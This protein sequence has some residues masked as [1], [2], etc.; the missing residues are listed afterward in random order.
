VSES[1]SDKLSR[2][3]ALKAIAAL[4]AITAVS[5]AARDASA[6]AK[7]SK[8]AVKYQDQPKNGQ[9]CSGCANF[10]SG[11]QCKIVQGEISPNGW[12]LAYS[13]KR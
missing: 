2:R 11:G 7:A 13:P 1:P 8:A 9:R 3:G 12:C 4:A 6:Q 10:I 5:G